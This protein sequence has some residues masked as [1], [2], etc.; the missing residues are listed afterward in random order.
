V[1]IVHEII[2]Y[3]RVIYT[4]AWEENGDRGPDTLVTMSFAEASPS[5]TKLTM[6]QR[7]FRTREERDGYKDAWEE[8]LD[9]FALFLAE[10]RDR[11]AGTSAM[12]AAE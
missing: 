11:I 4:Y 2:P 12:L 9:R 10:E 3:T 7:P 8:T 6:H 1:G 5:S